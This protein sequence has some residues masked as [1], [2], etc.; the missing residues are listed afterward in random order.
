MSSESYI[1]Q[2]ADQNS[3][4]LVVADLRGDGFKHALGENIAISANGNRFAVSVPRRASRDAYVKIYEY[5]EANGLQVIW[6]LEVWPSLNDTYSLTLSQSEILG[7]GDLSMS[8]D[9]YCLA[10]AYRGTADVIR[11]YEWTGTMYQPKGSDIKMPGSRD[12]RGIWYDHV[13]V[14]SSFFPTGQP[15]VVSLSGSGDR[16]AVSAVQTNEAGPV[17][18]YVAVL[19]Y[20]NGA[21][22]QVGSNI[23]GDTAGE[24]VSA[25]S[26]S[27][28]GSTLAIGLANK[29]SNATSSGQVKVFSLADGQWTQVGQDLNG[30]AEFD[31]FGESIS[32]SADGTIVSVGAPGANKYQDK[33]SFVAQITN[34][35]IIYNEWEELTATYD[36]QS[37]YYNKAT[38]RVQIDAPTVDAEYSYRARGAVKAFQY[39]GEE[40]HQVGDTITGEYLGERVGERVTITQDGSRIAVASKGAVDPEGSGVNSMLASGDFGGVLDIALSLVTSGNH[41]SGS[42]RLYDYV[43][44]NWQMVGANRT[45]SLESGSYNQDPGHGDQ[46]G[47]SLGISGNGLRCVVGA[48]LSS[49]NNYAGQAYF[50]SALPQLEGAGAPVAPAAAPAAAVGDPYILSANGKITKLPDKHGYYRML[51]NHDTFVNVEVAQRDI[52]RDMTAF[53]KSH[54]FDMSQLQGQK[55]IT[56]GYWNKAIFIES[57]GHAF[58]YDLFRKRLL[59]FSDLSYFTITNTNRFGSMNINKRMSLNDKVSDSLQVSWNHSSRGKQSITLDWYYNPQVQNGISFSSSLIKDPQSF[60]LFVKNYKAKYMELESLETGKSKQF[61]NRLKMARRAGKK[62]THEKPVKDERENWFINKGNKLIKN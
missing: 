38:G 9:G 50:Y 27:S 23:L 43:E 40:W 36:R 21:W 46:F 29:N 59:S 41:H 45:V 54:N 32:I 33:A 20:E 22:S 11:V 37:Y 19:D 39:Y 6:E 49:V 1:R 7:L 14:G 48:P 15:L 5:D 24:Y 47:A 16:V 17:A 26:L 44:S 25:V 28:D 56:T 52:T 58:S 30:E 2:S 8:T 57:E 34:A 3:A 53:L 35:F 13:N 55:L 12:T 42:I 18:G 10:V 61:S 4:L 51:E 60:G 31:L 62:L